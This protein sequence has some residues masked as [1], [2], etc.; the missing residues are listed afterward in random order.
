MRTRRGFTLV[1]AVVSTALLGVGIAASIAALGEM[2]RV[3][4]LV[5][6]R[7]QM[8]RLALEKHAELVAT[9]DY[10]LGQLEG[11]FTGTGRDRYLWTAT[12]EP[13]GVE[14][15]YRIVVTVGR[16]EG[17]DGPSETADGLLF[18]PPQETGAPVL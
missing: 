16:A 13:T 11:E 7:E 2:T 9:G 18:V 1:E 15:L 14:N 5:R 10:A 12:Y 4:S 6:E 3:E 17:E 8:Q